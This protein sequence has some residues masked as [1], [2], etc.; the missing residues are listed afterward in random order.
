MR[1]VHVLHSLAVAGAEVLVHDFVLSAPAGFEQ[2]VVTLDDLGALG[3]ALR[4]R[5]VTVEC[6]DRRPGFDPRLPLRLARYLNRTRA[7]V[8]HAHQYTPYFYS[9]LATRLLVRR[10][11]LIFTE[12]G[13]QVPDVRRPKRVVF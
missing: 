10:P 4:A 5:G 6:L 9:A 1:I 3:Q 7:D 13:R 8:V 12:H 11:A 2:S